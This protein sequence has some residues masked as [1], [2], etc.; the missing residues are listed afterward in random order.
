MR[1]LRFSIYVRGA[2]SI[3]STFDRFNYTRVPPPPLLLLGFGI[4]IIVTVIYFFLFSTLDSVPWGVFVLAC[5]TLDG[6][7]WIVSSGGGPCFD[8]TLLDLEW[9]A[10]LA[11]A[12]GRSN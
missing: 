9:C 2:F 11:G 4:G 6:F 8:V 1:S 5:Q 10:G 3:R 12:V 7:N